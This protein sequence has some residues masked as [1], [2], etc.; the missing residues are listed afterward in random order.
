MLLLFSRLFRHL[1]SSN[2]RRAGKIFS[3]GL[4]IEEHADMFREIASNDGGDNGG[5]SGGNGSSGGLDPARRTFA[6]IE[7]VRGMQESLGS[8]HR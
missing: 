1:T 2:R 6:N 4:D 3:S 5:T 8:L 7:F